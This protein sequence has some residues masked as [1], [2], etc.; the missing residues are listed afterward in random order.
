MWILVATLACETDI[1]L[2]DIIQ[3]GIIEIR[4]LRE[5]FC[6]FGIKVELCGSMFSF[7]FIRAKKLWIC[8]SSLHD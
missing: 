4:F 3:G 2:L 7:M 5:C 1:F 6:E 8:Q